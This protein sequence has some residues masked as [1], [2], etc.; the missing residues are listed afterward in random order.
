MSKHLPEKKERKLI[1]VILEKFNNRYQ[2]YA[3]KSL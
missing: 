2:Q 1:V 3:Y